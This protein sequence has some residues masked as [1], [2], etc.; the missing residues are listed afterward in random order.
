LPETSLDSAKTNRVNPGTIL[1]VE[2]DRAIRLLFS[3]VL[4]SKG[5]A[6][7]LSAARQHMHCIDAVITDS[8]MPGL[9]GRELMKAIRALRP[10]IPILVVS[11]SIEDGGARADDHAKT[12]RL[13]KPISPAQLTAEVGKLLREPPD[14]QPEVA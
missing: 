7:G 5:G 14:E 12:V 1:V 13:C 11:G 6:Q 4:R 2:D 10:D 9:D 3:H 8:T